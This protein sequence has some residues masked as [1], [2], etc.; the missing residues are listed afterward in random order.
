M[1]ERAEIIEDYPG[2]P[3]GATCLILAWTAGGRAL[4]AVVSYPP[5]V[6]IIT[7]YEPSSLKWE[8]L[9]TRRR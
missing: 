4:H 8:E 1:G 6:A 2:D 5:D 7:V 3:R 9:R